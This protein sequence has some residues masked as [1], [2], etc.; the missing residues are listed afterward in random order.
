M[1]RRTLTALGLAAALNLSVNTAEAGLIKDTLKLSAFGNKILL[2]EGLKGTKKA[3]VGG[4]KL[5]KASVQFNAFVAKC[6]VKAA[7]KKTC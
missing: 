5:A 6:A 7:L 1:I 3:L 4:A 2:K